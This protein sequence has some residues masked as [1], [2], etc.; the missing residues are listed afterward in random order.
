MNETRR[1]RPGRSVLRTVLLALGVAFGVGVGVGTWLRCQMERA[2]S[3]IGSLS[4][5]E[6]LARR[7]S[8]PPRRELPACSGRVS[9][10]PCQP[11]PSG[12]GSMRRIAPSGASVSR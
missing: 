12:A 7:V 10:R 11:A 5:G 4:A 8:P 6:D 2:P 1:S 9:W 3:Y